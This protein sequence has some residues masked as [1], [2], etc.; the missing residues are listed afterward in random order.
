M[1]HFTPKYRRNPNEKVHS[2]YQGVA[3]GHRTVTKVVKV[4]QDA[5]H[6]EAVRT[7][8]PGMERGQSGMAAHIVLGG[9]ETTLDE[10]EYLVAEMRQ[11]PFVPRHTGG[12]I[13]FMCQK[14]TER[15]N[16][17]I[18]YL[19]KNP[20]EAP[21]LNKKQTVRLHLPVG[22]RWASTPEP[23]LKILAKV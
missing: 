5:N 17:R 19:R 1:E 6:L 14:V 21:K 9:L 10:M 18:K 15:R 3:P 20:S 2:I 13:A 11:K 22:Y 8:G 12:E 4:A 16:E 23:G 7:Y